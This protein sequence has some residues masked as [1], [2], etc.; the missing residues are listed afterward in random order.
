[1]RTCSLAGGVLFVVVA[2]VVVAGGWMVVAGGVVVAGVGWVVLLAAD[3]AAG[4]LV[5]PQPANASASVSVARRVVA[6]GLWLA[7][8][9][10]L[11]I[12]AYQ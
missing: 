1:M 12:G 7:A 2:V 5:L 3:V 10:L 9:C 8:G 6:A 11:P 4:L